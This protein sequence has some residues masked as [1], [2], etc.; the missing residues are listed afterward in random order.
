MSK[1]KTGSGLKRKRSKGSKG[2]MMVYILITHKAPLSQLRLLFDPPL[3]S[4]S[5]DQDNLMA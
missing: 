4:V 5:P 3:A 1:E 2:W